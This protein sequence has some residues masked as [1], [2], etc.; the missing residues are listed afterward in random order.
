MTSL[1][2]VRKKKDAYSTRDARSLKR[3]VSHRLYPI[4]KEVSNQIKRTY[5][6]ALECIEMRWGTEVEGYNEIRS[7]ILRVGNDAVRKIQ[8]MVYGA[9]DVVDK[10][11][12]GYNVERIP[13]V[14]VV[15][16]STQE[17]GKEDGEEQ[18]V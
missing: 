1:K 12:D 10:A 6:T 4:N 5:I 7:K 16:T 11:V 2:N 9:V 3:E 14:T 15:N 17:K 13:Q 18:G 8:E